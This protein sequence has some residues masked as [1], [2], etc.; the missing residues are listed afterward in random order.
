MIPLV[1]GINVS[2]VTTDEKIQL[3]N[4][5]ATKFDLSTLT[6]SSLNETFTETPTNNTLIRSFFDQYS[7]TIGGTYY[8]QVSIINDATNN[9]FTI[10][11]YD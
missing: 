4:S 3:M 11:A 10:S 1:N 8:N 7:S 2:H 6:D 9:K 5:N